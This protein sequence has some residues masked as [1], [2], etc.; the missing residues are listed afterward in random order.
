M[1]RAENLIASLPDPP[2]WL[3]D[4]AVHVSTRFNASRATSLVSELSRLLLDGQPR[5][6]QALLERS[7]RPG[8]SMG[9]LARALE[10]FFTAGRLALPTDQ[11]ERLAA[12]RR[13]RR[14]DQTPE[15][16]RAGVGGFADYQ[17]RARQRALRAGTR[18]RSDNTIELALAV[19]RDLAVFLTGQ[20]GK[21][22]WSIADV[23]DVE[24]F[25]ADMPKARARRLTVLRQFFRFARRSRLVLI[26]PTMTLKAKQHS[27]FRGRTLTLGEQ[28]QVFRRWTSGDADVHPH[29]ALV[30]MLA[31]LHAASS[32]E[33]R[34]L[35]LDNIDHTRCSARLGD[36]PHPVPL[37]PAT[38][39]AL[40]R[41]LDHRTGLNTA[42][43]HV[44]VTKGTKAG[45]T[46]ASRAYLSHVL[47]PCGHP[48][49]AIRSTRLV[50]L[51][52]TLDPKLV[53]AAMGLD[54]QAPLIYLDDRIRQWPQEGVSAEPDRQTRP[55]R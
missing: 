10:D 32:Q 50:D 19:V 39:A 37:D 18:P 1:T 20:R 25:L 45:R 23:H 6:P 41:C 46:P 2:D 53:A 52:N 42:N 35:T 3:L 55:E 51:V 4:F 30:G 48:P 47:D 44:I 36:R 5:H 22:D 15:A 29:E 8:R 33:A 26:D 40:V 24:A 21:N 27:A 34:L 12:G 14:I 43:P 13:Q 7:R 17:M 11:A 28:R 38:W 16:L 54:P 31:L 49:R 9:P